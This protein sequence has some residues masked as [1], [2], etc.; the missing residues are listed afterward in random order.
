MAVCTLHVLILTLGFL[1][2]CASADYRGVGTPM[3]G[4]DGNTWMGFPALAPGDV[5][6]IG[7]DPFWE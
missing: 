7:G 4:P 3:T 6:V 1:A 5:F 2:S